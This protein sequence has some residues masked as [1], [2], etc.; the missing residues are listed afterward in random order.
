MIKAEECF[1]PGKELMEN[2]RGLQAQ[3]WRSCNP[4]VL[5]GGCVS[6]WISIVSLVG[7]FYFWTTAQE[8]ELVCSNQDANTPPKITFNRIRNVTSIFSPQ[9]SCCIS[10]HISILIRFCFLISKNAKKYSLPFCLQFQVKSQKAVNDRNPQQC[11]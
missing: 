3:T 2:K 6:D 10:M 5:L 11:Q 4:A 7:E 9:Q 8:V 1:V